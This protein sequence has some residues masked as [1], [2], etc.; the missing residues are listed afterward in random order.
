MPKDWMMC[1]P[2]LSRPMLFQQQNR[3]IHISAGGRGM[4]VSMILTDTY[5]YNSEQLQGGAF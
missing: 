2:K 4:P 3:P 5:K 1:T